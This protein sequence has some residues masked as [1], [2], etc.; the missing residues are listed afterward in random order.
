MVT[1]NNNKEGDNINLENDNK[2]KMRYK[3]TKNNNIIIIKDN[4][5]IKNRRMLKTN[6]IIK[7][8]CFHVIL[9]IHSHVK[10]FFAPISGDHNH[11]SR[12]ESNIFKLN[13]L[14][15]RDKISFG[16]MPC[17]NIPSLTVLLEKLSDK[18]S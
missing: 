14:I 6:K 1:I 4:M 8:V 18:L 16:A 3:I 12:Y 13:G 7:S 17:P 9:H 10:G 5:I 11:V 15:R 2:G